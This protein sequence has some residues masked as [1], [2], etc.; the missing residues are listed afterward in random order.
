MTTRDDQPPADT[1]Q[2][3]PSRI[4]VKRAR[5]RLYEQAPEKAE[6][7]AQA[8]PKP[9]PKG[10]TSRRAANKPTATGRTSGRA[11]ATDKPPAGARQAVAK[12]TVKKR[13]AEK[14][15][16]AAVAA[17]A[18]AG[19]R[20]GDDAA[21]TTKRSTAAGPLSDRAGLR[22]RE[23]RKL[24]KKYALFSSATG[25]IPVPLA[26]LVA[27]SVLQLRML[28]EL[29][30]LYGIEYVEER[31]RIYL[32]ALI[33]TLAPLTLSRPTGVL[34]AFF[35]TVPVVGTAAGLA[36]FPGTLGASTYALGQV[37]IQH[38]ENGGTLLDFDPE[39]A[40][41]ALREQAAE[42]EGS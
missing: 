7:A 33:S 38:F 27:L 39:K 8:A 26:D 21:P 4:K 3:E 42:A 12:G 37:F 29:T 22:Q 6:P 2:D 14:N 35:R 24:V 32:G 30:A 40:R 28:K 23:A 13:I 5:R 34:R 31:S 20:A 18:S 16:P 19:A 15:K 9:T 36:V 17:S 25:F 10:S 1:E 11:V 41:H